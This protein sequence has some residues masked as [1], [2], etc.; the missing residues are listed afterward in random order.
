MNFLRQ[1]FAPKIKYYMNTCEFIIGGDVV[2]PPIVT[3]Y[4]R[5]GP[6]LYTLYDDGWEYYTDWSN[7][8]HLNL[9]EATEEEVFLEFI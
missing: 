4:K 9:V 2:K 5:I 1:I 8:K 3:I 6:Y 7:R